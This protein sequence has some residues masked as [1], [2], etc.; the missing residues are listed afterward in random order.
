MC[1]VEVLTELLVLRTVS[2]ANSIL[3]IDFKI[4]LMILLRVGTLRVMQEKRQS[5]D[6][7]HNEV[8]V[9]IGDLYDPGEEER[10]DED[11]DK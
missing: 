5:T 7:S 9:G 11:D 4:F 1:D 3:S 8:N 6:R 2:D 10:G